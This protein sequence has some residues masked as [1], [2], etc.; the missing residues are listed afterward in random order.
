MSG[1]FGDLPGELR[2][3]E[4]SFIRKPF[5]PNDLLN[6][7]RLLLDSPASGTPQE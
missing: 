6:R 1:Y 5:M 3:D 4:K 7:V 2:V